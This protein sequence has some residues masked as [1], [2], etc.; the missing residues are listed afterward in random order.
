MDPIEKINVMGDSTFVLMMES[1]KRFENSYF[2]TPDDLFSVNN[3]SYGKIKQCLVS[4]DAPHFTIIKEE[5]LCLAEFDLI[6]MR[7]DPPFDMSYIFT[8]YML[9][10]V[11]KSTLVLNDPNSIRSANE[12]MVALQF[13]EFIP[14]TLVTHE[15]SRAKEFAAQL[16]D[17]VVIK[18]WDGNGGRGVL[19]SH[20]KDPNFTSMLEIL[21]KEEREF[22]IV[23]E[24]VEEVKKGDKRIILINGEVA[25][26]MA[27]I[28]AENDHR[29]NMHVGATI[30]SFELSDRD[31]EICSTIGPFLKKHNL[32]FVGIDI[33]GEYLTEIN[34]T[35][36]TGIQEINKLQNSQLEKD[37]LDAAILK[38][39]NKQEQKK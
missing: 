11:P 35:S 12:K 16:P 8:T 13:K 15:I 19:I 18:P 37:V 1:Q 33:I 17:K 2:C 26:W 20:H 32:L 38:H 21:T 4:W 39:K 14:K 9:D 5:D 6:F 24:Y 28:P 23:Q 7:K 25:G 30:A 29:G 34:V 36:P 31:K 22:I 27:R 3:L 10:L